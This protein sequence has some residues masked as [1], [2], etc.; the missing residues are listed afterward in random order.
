MSEEQKAFDYRVLLA[1]AGVV[2]TG[3]SVVATLSIKLYQVEENKS[4]IELDRAELLKEIRENRASIN[5]VKDQV[6]TLKSIYM[7]RLSRNPFES[8]DE[9]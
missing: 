9:E 2:I 3:L 5:Q 4:Q 1:C 8:E 6:N 7:H